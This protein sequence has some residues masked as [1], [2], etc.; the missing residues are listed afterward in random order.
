MGAL[1][2]AQ[3]AGGSSGVSYT[4]TPIVGYET[5]VKL[6]PTPHSHARIMYGALVTGGYERLS[7]EVEYT[8]AQDDERFALQSLNIRDKDERLKLGLRTAIRHSAML[9]TKFRGGG[10]ASRNT[11][12]EEIAGVKSKVVG[13]IKY[14]PYV[15]AGIG[16]RV[17]SFV[18]LN[19]AA[20][21]VLNEIPDMSKT[22][23]EYTVGLTFSKP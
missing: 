18:E 6:R 9:S 1:H 21:A 2:V 11:H 8:Q 14:S 23:Y 17:M 13:K 16:V 22:N 10:Q 19:L 3:A 4:V 7:G 12:E 15:G 20:T 5:A